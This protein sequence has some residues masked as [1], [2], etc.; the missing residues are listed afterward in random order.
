MSQRD[1]TNLIFWGGE[2]VDEFALNQG[3]RAAN[4]GRLGSSVDIARSLG[5]ITGM[6]KMDRRQLRKLSVRKISGLVDV[7]Q[8]NKPLFDYRITSSKPLISA[9]MFCLVKVGGIAGPTTIALQH[10]RGFIALLMKPYEKFYLSINGLGKI[11][12]YKDRKTTTPITS[13]LLANLINFNF[14]V[15]GILSPDEGYNKTA[16]IDIVLTF[17]SGEKIYLRYFYYFL[18]FLLYFNLILKKY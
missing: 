6:E 10:N 17:I 12:F 2:N 7:S 15:D 3:R 9:A 14:E 13:I 4:M 16:V 5:D 8:S 1:P 11:I 18:Y